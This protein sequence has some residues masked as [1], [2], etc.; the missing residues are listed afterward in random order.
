MGGTPYGNAPR[1]AQRMNMRR[2]SPTA[3]GRVRPS[4]VNPARPVFQTLTFFRG[5]GEK[6]DGGLFNIFASPLR[7]T[8]VAFFMFTERE[9]QLKFSLAVV[10]DVI[11]NGHGRLPQHPKLIPVCGLRKAPTKFA[12]GTH[13]RSCQNGS[14]ERGRFSTGRMGDRI[15]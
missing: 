2:R 9:N 13:R 4:P 10:T 1:S 3:G 8:D 7:A 12:G 6:R 15:T 14:G 5:H 11:V